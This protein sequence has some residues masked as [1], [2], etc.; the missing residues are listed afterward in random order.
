MKRILVYCEGPTEESFVKNVLDPYFWSMDVSVSPKGASGVSKYSVIKKELTRHCKHDSTT[1]ITTMLDYYG[2]PN[3]TPGIST[4]KGSIYDK[5]EHIEYAVKKDLGEL[6]NLI[7]NLSLHEFEGL[8]FSR[9]SAFDIVADKKQI[10]ALEKVHNDFETPEHINNSYNTAPSRR[11]KEIVP[12][13]QKIVDGTQ[14]AQ[15]IGIDEISAK[16]NHFKRWLEKLIAWA[17]DY[18]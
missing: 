10:E 2:L 17:K 18:K 5:V 11:I 8:L 14:I 4:A 13:Y 12:S 7:F 16:C 9:V 1:M 6:A 3:D 15:S